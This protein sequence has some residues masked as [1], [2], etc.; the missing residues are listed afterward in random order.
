ITTTTMQFNP[1]GLELERPQQLFPQWQPLPQQP[2]FLQQEPEQPY[3]QQQPL[4]QQQPFPQQPQLPHQHQFPQQLPQQQFPQ[5][6][7]LQP[8]QQF[9]QQMPLQPQQQP[10]F[11][12]QKPFGQYQQPLTQQPYPQQQPLAQQQPS[13]EEQHQLNLCK[14]FLLQ[15]CTLDEKVPLL[16]SVISFL[17]PHISQQNSCQLKRQQCCQQL[18][19]INEQSRCPAIQTIVHAIVMQ[20]QVQQQVG[21]GFV[22][23]QLQQLGQGMPIQLQQQP[24]Q[25]FVLPQQQAQFKVVGSLVIQTLPMLCNVHVPP[26]CSPFGSMATGSGG[27]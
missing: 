21:H 17:R 19:N 10:Q 5:Q 3:P 6:M 13:I 11:P 15:Q 8:Q 9:P 23:S 22:Q 16:Q 14:E 4:P 20:Q 12:Q 27:Q 1:S 18:A 2:P 7:P 24:G 26:Y 25:A